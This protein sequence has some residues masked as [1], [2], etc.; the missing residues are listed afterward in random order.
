MTSGEEGSSNWQLKLEKILK[1]MNGVVKG[2]T[3][4]V[5]KTSAAGRNFSSWS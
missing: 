1:R 4:S 2:S 3:A 5:R